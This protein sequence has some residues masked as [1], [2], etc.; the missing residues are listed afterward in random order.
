MKECPPGKVLNIKTNRCNKEKVA[1]ECPPGKVLNLATNR[2]IKERKEKYRITVPKPVRENTDFSRTQIDEMIDKYINI[3]GTEEITQTYKGFIFFHDIYILYLLKKYKNTCYSVSGAITPVIY[4]DNK[5]YPTEDELNNFVD[6]TFRCIVEKKNDVI[7][8]PVLVSEKEDSIETH[9][10]VLVYR[11]KEHHIELF[12]PHGAMYKKNYDKSEIIWRHLD[13]YIEALNNTLEQDFKMKPIKFL[14]SHDICP[15]LDGMQV[16][17]EQGR[18]LIVLKNKKKERTVYEPAG[19]CSI[20]GL[21]FI[22]LV[23][24]NPHVPSKDLIM[25]V[26]NKVSA[27]NMVNIARGYMIKVCNKLQQYYSAMLGENL[28][29]TSIIEAYLLNENNNL[30]QRAING[31]LTRIIE[32]ERYLEVINTGTNVTT[33][34]YQDYVDKKVELLKNHLDNHSTYSEVNN[35]INKYLYNYYTSQHKLVTPDKTK[36]CPLGKQLNL[37][38]HRCKTVKKPK[39]CPQGKVMNP[40]TKRCNK[41]KQMA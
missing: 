1:K 31:A 21:F 32:S 34:I 13:K 3:G 24:K 4:T 22:E 23:L 6:V 41:I 38:T 36:T 10:N 25:S 14:S 20:W 19:F 2:C 17:E 5:L 7:V 30:T 16:R 8:I 37:K 27:V 28:N 9:F 29:T 33:K 26:L 39:T 12:E 35:R 15:V 40:T 18:P 11:R